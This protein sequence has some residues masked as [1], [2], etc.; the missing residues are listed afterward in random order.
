[1]IFASAMLEP[2]LLPP[3][4]VGGI[5]IYL[6]GRSIYRLYFHPLRLIPGPK[7]AAISHIY[8]FYF[9]VIVGG[10]FMFEIGRLHKQYGPIIRINPREVHIL[11][12]SFYDEIYSGGVR[13]RNKDAEFLKAYSVEGSPVATVD[14]DHHRYRRNIVGSFFSKRSV[15]ELSPV[16]EDKIQKL[17][18][19]FSIANQA[20]SVVRLDDAFSALASDVITQYS[21]GRSWDF[22]ED[23]NFRREIRH[24][25]AET[26]NAIHINRF[27]P[28]FARTLR[29]IPRSLVV[30]IQPGKQSVVDFMKSIYD[31]TAQSM[32]VA[33][34][35]GHEKR[36][37]KKGTIFEKLTDPTLP[38]EERTFRRIHDE[39]GVIL[40][41]GTEA[42]GRSL[43]VAAFH[44]AHNP[45]IRDKVR[46]ELR[47]VMPTPTSK[48]TGAQLEQLPYLS[49]VI[50]EA[51][52]LSYGMTLRLP[53]CAPAEALKYEDYVLPPGT[54]LSMSTYLVHHDESI[55]PD[56]FSFKPER[57][58]EVGPNADRLT[59]YMVSFTRG[60]RQCLGYNL[61][62]H[63]LYL[64]IS[65]FV[66]QFDMELY[67]T[68][69]DD[70][71]IVSD[72]GLGLTRNG[73]VEVLVKVSNV[74]KD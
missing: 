68:T 1:M 72:Y 62:F 22:L 73:E 10:Q 42:I 57:W 21:F 29:M 4:L 14:H 54:P 16:I 49:G 37:S 39:S 19:R 27:F 46:E 3:L 60:S 43:T 47:S 74:L 36:D 50:W 67:K 40:Q 69:L 56:S 63:V 41:A 24:A 71:T 17:M 61:S 53:R 12:P 33:E 5:L 25:I 26:A 55:F 9:D 11:D 48:A 34:N 15:N 51:L 66:R 28:L 8:E 30:K 23:V 70:L 38:P 32:Q 64:T 52:R 58:M 44:I 20:G 65:S 18:E 31:F 59:K 2:S 6:I 35:P 13:K 45:S 7:L